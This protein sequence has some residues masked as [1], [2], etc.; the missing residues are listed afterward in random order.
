VG[1]DNAIPPDNTHVLQIPRQGAGPRSEVRAWEPLRRVDLGIFVLLLLP[2]VMLLVNVPWIV[3]GIGAGLIDPDFYLGYFLDLAGHFRIFPPNYYGSRLAWI[4]PGY[5]AYA[6]F[7]PLLANYVLHFGT[8]YTAVFSHYLILKQTVSQKAALVSAIL[9]G[10]YCYFLYALGWNYVDGA[11]MTYLLL[12]ILMM[13]YA[14][15]HRAGLWIGMSGA[16]FAAMIHSNLFLGVFALP[17]LVYYWV[18]VRHPSRP[19][20]QSLTFFLL[21]FLTI[22]ILLG[23]INRYWLGGGFLFWAPSL[24]FA[25]RSLNGNAWWLPFGQWVPKAVWLVLPSLALV[26]ACGFLALCLKLKRDISQ[27][28]QILFQ[29]L[30]VLSAAMF[31]TFELIGLPVL[32]IFL[33][34]SYLIP[35]SFLAIGAQL[36]PII[37]RLSMRQFGILLFALVTVL[38]LGYALAGAESRPEQWLLQHLPWLVAT[39]VVGQIILLLRPTSQRIRA[40]FLLLL[41]VGVLSMVN[42]AAQSIMPWQD[43]SLGQNRLLSVVQAVR[44]IRN[45]AP[46]TNLLFWYNSEEP[47]GLLYRS[48]ASTYLWNYFLVNESFPSL[49]NGRYSTHSPK[50]FSRIAIFSNQQD[51]FQK[52][53]D[54]LRRIGFKALLLRDE[55]FRQGP[56]TWKMVLLQVSNDPPGD[57]DLT[58]Q[59]WPEEF[60]LPW[61]PQEG[62]NLSFTQGGQLLFSSDLDTLNGWYVGRY[63]QSGGLAIKADGLARG[64]KCGLYSSGEIRDH[65]A[66]PFVEG[67]PVQGLAFFSIWVKALQE[68]Q[69]PMV[70]VQDEHYAIVAD[71]RIL[72]TRPDGWTLVGNWVVLQPQQ[73]LRLLVI[74]APGT[75]SLLDKALLVDFPN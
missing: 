39:I 15:S 25:K 35:F 23:G 49:D 74:Q 66:S 43:L 5:A 3:S 75:T 9:M 29:V 19:P 60:R 38:I 7:P 51:A 70:S 44:T 50:L 6:L 71:S 30:L 27:R 72:M 46:G 56:F 64:D 22:N 68:G 41:A 28:W 55:S 40:S 54:A 11:G 14:R 20:L 24:T 53:D 10:S 12:A 18:G 17:L 45:F 61:E 26:S 52:A 13:T 4:L 67:P 73:K 34:A 2:W 59:G 63:G 47:D 31:V 8:Y 37:D 21:G 65:L 69:F 33:Y 48:M 62:R 32:Q 58:K 16:A 42:T 1:M 57:L 36:S